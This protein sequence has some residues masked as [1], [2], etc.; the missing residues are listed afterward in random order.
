MAATIQTEM[1]LYI[2]Q[3]G[4]TVTRFAERIGIN[5]GTVS[6][7]LNG[8]RSI[9]VTQLDRITEVMGLPEGTYYEMFLEEYLAA[10]SLDWRRIGP[11]FERCAELDKLLLMQQAARRVMDNL[12]YAGPLFEMAEHWYRENKWEAAAILYQTVADSEKYQHSERLAVCHYRLFKITLG[13][14]Q[15][16]N[17]QAASRF[18][19]YVD[20][21]DETEQ[22]DALKD[23]IDI[24]ASLQRYDKVDELA[25][26]LG[27]KSR[28][29]YDLKHKRG[30]VKMQS[31]S[32]REPLMPLVGYALY[33]YLMR[34]TV[35]KEYGQFDK[36]LYYTTLY[37]NPDWVLEGDLESLPAIK[38]FQE[39][40]EA[41]VHLYKLMAGDAK[42]LL[43]YIAYITTC[44][45]ELLN[46]LFSVLQASI[47]HHLNVDKL[48]K[49]YQGYILKVF[50][51]GPNNN[52]NHQVMNT[53]FAHFLADLAC[54]Y[55]NQQKFDVGINWIIKSL[56]YSVRINQEGCIIRCVGLFERFRHFAKADQQSEYQKII[57]E[58]QNNDEKEVIGRIS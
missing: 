28:I 40:A 45:D 18:E 6:N 19:L 52:Y 33:S 23:L 21:L 9:S 32:N 30:K 54:Y 2:K 10:S 20:R 14:N 58:A 47:R 34:G 25:E 50:H 26:K 53:K 7:I 13:D 29:L 24:Y 37:N 51:Q 8:H 1:E 57:L 42:A 39:W 16:V 35:C 22:L 56:A 11:F 41:N 4:L 3:E 46:G 27:S 31:S 55:L 17:A 43:K 5:A 38:K 12:S 15:E 36:A 44:E 48:L 49:E